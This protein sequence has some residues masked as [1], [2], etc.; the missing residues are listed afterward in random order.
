MTSA[1]FFPFVIVIDLNSV[2]DWQKDVHEGSVVLLLQLLR[3][4]S[5]LGYYQ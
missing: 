2:Y 4:T 5:A 3:L 1:I